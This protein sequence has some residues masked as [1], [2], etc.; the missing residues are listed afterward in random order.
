MKRMVKTYKSDG[1]DFGTECPTCDYCGASADETEIAENS[2]SG[3][4]M[5]GEIGCWNDYIW[6]EVWGRMIEV[7]EE[8]INVCETCE[9]PTDE[10]DECMDCRIDRELDEEEEDEE[11]D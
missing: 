2:I 11:S 7:T 10:G 4:F 3:G 8:E 1:Y 6:A 9:E 5:C